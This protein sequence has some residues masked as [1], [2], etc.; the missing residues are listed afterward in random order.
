MNH[1]TAARKYL[2][3]PFR[4]RG[5]NSRHLDCLGL[6]IVSLADTGFIVTND[7]KHYGRE[8]HTDGLREGLQIAFGEPCTDI[9]VGDIALIAYNTIVPHHV[10]LIGDYVY[11]GLSLIHADGMVGKVVEHRLDDN[12]RKMILE[13]Y[14]ISR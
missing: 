11:G 9:Q 6:V 14:R 1:V 13:T 7:K 10:A 8:P 2:N 4:H 5:R 3:V 12:W